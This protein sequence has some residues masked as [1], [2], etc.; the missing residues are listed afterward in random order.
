MFRH[1]PPHVQ[2]R[3]KIEILIQNYKTVEV[4]TTI[5]YSYQDSIPHRACQGTFLHRELKQ[6]SSAQELEVEGGLATAY[7]VPFHL[8]LQSKAL[9]LD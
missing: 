6:P 8:Y 7:L 5:L 4:N 1:C 2:S 3:F 9:D